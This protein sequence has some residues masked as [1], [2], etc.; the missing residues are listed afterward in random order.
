MAYQPGTFTRE[1]KLAHAA[2][3]H[4]EDEDLDCP[5]CQFQVVP[6]G[7]A[8]LAEYDAAVMDGA[9]ALQAGVDAHQRGEHRQKTD[10][11]CIVCAQTKEARNER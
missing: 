11:A 4:A 5:A 1:L 8:S 3:E 7:F 10:D 6:D 9:Q 2:G